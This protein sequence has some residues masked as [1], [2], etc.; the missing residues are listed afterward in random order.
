MLIRYLFINVCAHY[1]PANMKMVS[2]NIIT[3]FKWANQTYGEAFARCVHSCP[4]AASAG[5]MRVAYAARLPPNTTFKSL[6]LNNK[7]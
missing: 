6:I 1:G 2:R 4:A 3:A 5:E 7:P